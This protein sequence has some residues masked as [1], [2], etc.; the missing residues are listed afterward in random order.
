VTYGSNP[1]QTVVSAHQKSVD[2]YFEATAKGW[3]EIYELDT[4]YARIHQERG[5]IVLS[6]AGSVALPAES[7]VLEIGCGAGLATVALAERGYA[8]E[9]VDTVRDMLLTTVARA[10]RAGIADRIR[11]IQASADHLP[12]GNDQFSLVLAIGV[13]P[14]LGC[15]R[16]ALMEFIRVTK[17]GGYLIV[18]VD[19]SWRLHELLDP[20]LH[21]VHRRLRHY[22]HNVL[23]LPVKVPPTQ[24]C[25]A[26]QFNRL[27]GEL[28]CT[29]VDEKML[30]FG[31]FSFLGRP[32]LSEILNIKV[33]KFLQR[34]ADR[35]LPIIRSTAA[36][37]ITLLRKRTGT[38]Q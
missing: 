28:Q 16:T 30:G 9:A 11:V 38:G 22:L 13:L 1:S 33:N 26:R 17:P 5:R 24:R 35:Q 23:R 19:N 10:T 25:S 37:Y 27:I 7:R 15:I 36:Q 21:P 2:K 31:P 4:L 29:K 34:C 20:R 3:D 8:V 32:F 14:W 6:M 12:Y 18:N